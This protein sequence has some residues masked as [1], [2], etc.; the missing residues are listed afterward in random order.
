MVVGEITVKTADTLPISTRPVPVKLV[1]VIVTVVPT[2]PLV[3]AMPLIAGVGACVGAGGTPGEMVNIVPTRPLMPTAPLE[4]EPTGVATTT[5]AGPVAPPGTVAVMVVGDTT[6]N[7]A[8]MVVAPTWKVIARVPVKLFPVMVTVVPGRP[9]A[10]LRA[11]MVGKVGIGDAGQIGVGVPTKQ[12]EK[13][14]SGKTGGGAGDGGVGEG[15]GPLTTSVATTVW[16]RHGGLSG[17]STGQS[18]PST[19]APNCRTPGA[20][21]AAPV[22]VSG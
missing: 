15:G 17:T 2:G 6:V 12:T 9:L 21:L 14:G 16:I 1:P 3:G 5:L 7:R 20:G 10:G 19:L 22:I 13:I 8:G 4:A 11:E 18:V